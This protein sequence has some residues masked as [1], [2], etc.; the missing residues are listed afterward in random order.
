MDVIIAGCIPNWRKASDFI[1][2][3]VMRELRPRLKLM[4]DYKNGDEVQVYAGGM[5]VRARKG[6][7]K[8][9]R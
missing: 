4:D 3:L 7:E 6:D 5:N 9:H 2:S 8:I 1:E